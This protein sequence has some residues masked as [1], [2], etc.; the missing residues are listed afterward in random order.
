LTIEDI[1]IIQR[2]LNRKVTIVRSQRIHRLY[3]KSIMVNTDSV[4]IYL[5][6][7]GFYFQT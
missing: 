3:R 1:L 7:H 2:K 4:E 6:G 5:N